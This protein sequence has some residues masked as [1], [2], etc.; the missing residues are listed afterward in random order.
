MKSQNRTALSTTSGASSRNGNSE[1]WD[2]ISR[3]DY[4]V[5]KYQLI[6]LSRQIADSA[7][8]CPKRTELM[9]GNTTVA[10]GERGVHRTELALIRGGCE[11]T[12]HPFAGTEQIVQYRQALLKRQHLQII[13]IGRYELTERFVRSVDEV[14]KRDGVSVNKGYHQ[15]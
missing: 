3:H 12:V 2:E 14:T 5:V 9:Y 4:E 15:T 6:Y 10:H 1:W 11:R 8:G 7:K 13:R